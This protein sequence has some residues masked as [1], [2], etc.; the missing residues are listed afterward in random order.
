MAV[1]TSP[2]RTRPRFGL[3]AGLVAA[4]RGVAFAGLMLAG[5][6]L[7]IVIASG[8]FFTALGAGGLIVG[9][10]GPRDQRV[11]LAL[12]AVGTGLGLL[13]FALPP[14]LL[15]IRWLARLTRQ[16]AGHWCG[17]PI[18][19]QYAPPPAGKLTFTERLR[20]LATDP[21]TWRDLGWT[22]ANL[23]VCALAVAPVVIIGI[24]L[25]G[26]IGP[27][28]TRLIPPP[29][30][31]GNTPRTLTVLGVAITLAGVA[32]APLLLRG[33][34][35][36][37]RMLLAPAGQ[38]ELALRVRQLTQTRTEALDT[39]AAE[40][41]RI[42]RDLHDGAQ[43]RL[44]AMGM[45]LDA[46]GQ[47]ID[48]N[49]DAAR[50]LVLEARDASVKALAELRAL[51]RGIHPPVLADRGLADAIRALAL[52]A[53][54][55]ISLASD[56]NGRLPAPV[57]SAAYFAVCELLAN[58]SKHA[59]ARQTWVDIRHTDGMLRI[60][61]TDN[62]HGGAEAARGTG[63]R[64]IERR[65]AAFDGVLAISSPPGGPTAVTMEVPCALSS[66]KTSSC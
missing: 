33:Y 66:P 40:I 28:L 23:V 41:R 51:V 21:V 54:A 3:Q 13:R 15:G 43:A 6:G 56:L 20:W 52:D 9:N 34:G 42:E 39:G 2:R 10:G 16:L 17:V 35:L 44:V 65:L 8:L 58:V 48:S 5:L 25:I 22:S 29:A 62:G 63:L 14:A 55:R 18:A 64:G 30:F 32:A 24:G 57:E 47:I 38:A 50:A 12:L 26:F 37:I 11:L 19:G 31:P 7:L 4:T 53:S 1:I 59:E 27:E 46:A 45:T 60:G 36:L 61:V 49:P